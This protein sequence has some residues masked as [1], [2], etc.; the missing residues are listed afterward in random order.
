MEEDEGHGKKAEDEGVFFGFGDDQGRGR[1]GN[2]PPKAPRSR[3]VYAAIHITIHKRRPAEKIL[4]SYGE[5]K[6][7]NGKG[8]SALPDPRNRNTVGVV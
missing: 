6:V 8:Q 7:T 2:N 3:K 4:A 5:G 1:A